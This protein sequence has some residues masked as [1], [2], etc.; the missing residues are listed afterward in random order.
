MTVRVTP[1]PGWRGGDGNAAYLD[2]TLRHGP[3]EEYF[4]ESVGVRTIGRILFQAFACALLVSVFASIVSVSAGVVVGLAVF[5][6]VFVLSKL[7]QPIGEWRVVLEDRALASDS[8]Y[9]AIRGKLTER[10]LPIQG[11]RARRTREPNGA[12]N[13]RL[14]LVDGHYQVYVSVFAYGSSL[15]LGWMMYRTRRGSALLRRFF[16]DVLAAMTRRVDDVELML[17]TERPRAMR[18][19]VH[20]LCREGLNVAVERIEV[21]PEYGFPEG[22]PEIELLPAT[23]SPGPR[24]PTAPTPGWPAPAGTMPTTRHG[25]PG[26]GHA[27]NDWQAGAGDPGTGHTTNGWQVDAGSG[28]SGM[29]YVATGWQ[30][31][32]TES[33]VPAAGPVTNGWQADSAEAGDS[34]MAHLVGW[35]AS[36]ADPTATQVPAGTDSARESGTGHPTTDW[37]QPPGPADPTIGRHA[38]QPTGTRHTSVGRHAGGGAA[39]SADPGVG[40]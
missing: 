24:P 38:G 25:D 32:P 19:V 34:G 3:V 11:I 40:R 31:S 23:S 1:L 2:K 35:Q 5:V 9:S 30:A 36:P 33:V 20:A 26:A 15:Y 37:H 27:P 28:D 4:D 17:R 29:G 8:V 21:S 6:L 10:Q 16:G 14:V 12:V 7:D 22:L 13:N 39:R 18:E